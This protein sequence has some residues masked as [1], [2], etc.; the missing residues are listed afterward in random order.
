MAQQY[1]KLTRRCRANMQASDIYADIRPYNDE[2]VSEVLQRLLAS[3]DL[4]QA[5]I[6]FNLPWLPS[7]IRNL[8]TPVLRSIL[9]K[10]L[11]DVRTVEQFQLRSEV[12][13]SELQSRPHL[14]CRLLLEKIKDRQIQYALVRVHD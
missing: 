3:K 12:H 5:I 6:G 7:R 2:E 13:T 8:F 4:H 9:K 14:V 10:Q 1:N 11:R